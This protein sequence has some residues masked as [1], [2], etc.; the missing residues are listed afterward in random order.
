MDYITT[1]TKAPCNYIKDR[2][3]NLA[4]YK[5]FKEPE[6]KMKFIFLLKVWALNPKTPKP[7]NLESIFMFKL[8]SKY[9]VS[10]LIDFEL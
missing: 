5:A 9:K 3:A 6:Q 2:E 1:F 8:I 10:D 7:L 4:N